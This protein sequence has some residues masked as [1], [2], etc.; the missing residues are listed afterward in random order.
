MKVK[1]FSLKNLLLLK[2][3]LILEYFFK[4]K[5]LKYV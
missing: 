1:I 5:Y 3:R 2:E 4:N